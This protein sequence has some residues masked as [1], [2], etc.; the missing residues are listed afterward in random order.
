LLVVVVVVAHLHHMAMEQLA[1]VVVELVVI[2][3][4][5]AQE[6]VQA[7]LPTYQEIQVLVEALVEPQQQTDQE[8]REL[9]A[10]RVGLLLHFQVK[11]AMEW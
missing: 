10:G 3:V 5:P 4:H 1:E 6:A 11:V 7:L 9:E 2:V 8:M